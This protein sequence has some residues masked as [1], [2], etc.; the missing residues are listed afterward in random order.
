MIRRCLEHKEKKTKGVERF[1]IPKET[2]HGTEIISHQLSEVI[3]SKQIVFK[4]FYRNEHDGQ[5]CL[6][7]LTP[8]F[9]GQVIFS[10]FHQVDGQSTKKYTGVGLGLAITKRLAE[11][12]KGTVS[13]KSDLNKGSTFRVV[14]PDV[15]FLRN[16]EKK[17]PGLYINPDFI[18][19]DEAKI[20]VADD[21]SQNR[22]FITDIL[23]NTS[24]K[25][26]EAEN[27]EQAFNIAKE[28]ILDLDKAKAD[29]L[30][31]ISHEIRT[32]LNGILGP[33]DLLKDT[34]YTRDI[35]ELVEIL[36]MSV[37]RLER[38]SLN[39][40][41]ITRLKTKQVEIKKEK[42]QLSKLISEVLDEE[43]DIIQSGKV[44]AIFNDEAAGGVITCEAELIKKSITNILDNAI[45]FSPPDCSIEIKTY[46][47]DQDIICEIKDQ[48]KGFEKRV[49][50]SAFELFTTGPEYHDNCTGIGLPVTKMI[51]EAHGGDIIIG[52][53]PEGGARVKLLFRK[54]IKS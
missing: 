10:S 28:I 5:I 3:E 23:R 15:T 22:K 53:V 49:I 34:A 50:D 12:M 1:S 19:F 46:I 51:M 18:I 8:I 24:L 14:I 42:I 40:L 2:A 41:L 13:V 6:A 35:V 4:D 11:L 9:G 25:I 45:R 26:F 36:D 30:S 31:L 48:G 38:F 44:K 17:E 43:K 32:P 52:N 21:V 27:G 16:V 39:A 54:D 37:K 20:I 7:V 29:F 33:L 47:E